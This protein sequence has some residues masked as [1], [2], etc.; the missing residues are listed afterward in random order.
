MLLV[1]EASNQKGAQVGR[2]PMLSSWELGREGIAAVSSSSR[3]L[4]ALSCIVTFAGCVA[5]PGTVELEGSSFEFGEVGSAVWLHHRS[6]TP[7]GDEVE[8]HRFLVSTFP[9]ACDSL[10]SAAEES[11]P[12]FRDFY[13]SLPLFPDGCPEIRAAFGALAAPMDR[14]TGPGPRWSVLR[15][16]T[17][18][19]AAGGAQFPSEG[20]FQLGDGSTAG[21]ALLEVG[22]FQENPYGAM[23]SRGACS[24]SGLGS[25]TIWSETQT[26]LVVEGGTVEVTDT[27][28]DSVGISIVGAP[29]F[30]SNWNA[31]TLE[32][33]LMP[34]G[35]VG[36]E[37]T[38]EYCRVESDGP[39][40]LDLFQVP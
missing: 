11:G 31:T 26:R 25:P 20:R 1:F 32:Y 15:F 18:P 24:P 37:A 27:D 9:D 23:E 17:S 3:G 13:S 8:F 10:R 6:E 36:V 19:D 38:F 21:E 2:I 34:A 16:N 28:D 30:D 29:I 12:L 35:T 7:G 4:V 14:L 39:V 5:V 40:N 22:W 33:E